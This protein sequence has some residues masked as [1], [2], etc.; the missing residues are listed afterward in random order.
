MRGTFYWKSV[1]HNPLGE[2]IGFTQIETVF[3]MA[4]APPLTPSNPQAYST[5]RVAPGP[6]SSPRRPRR[7]PPARP[8]RRA[9][10][11]GTDRPRGANEAAGTRGRTLPL[12]LPPMAMDEEGGPCFANPPNLKLRWQ[13]VSA[14]VVRHRIEAVVP[15]LGAD[16]LASRAGEPHAALIPA[17]APHSPSSTSSTHLPSQWK[18]AAR[19]SP[20]PRTSKTF[21]LARHRTSADKSLSAKRSVACRRATRSHPELH[22]SWPPAPSL[23]REKTE[24]KPSQSTHAITKPLG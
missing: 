17:T 15:I 8:P 12:G 1:I 19:A 2:S 3:G 21:P 9:R 16:H 5:P 4:A 23:G 10:P 6:P 13:V 14:V 20:V 11:P 7:P 22:P 24:T 18:S